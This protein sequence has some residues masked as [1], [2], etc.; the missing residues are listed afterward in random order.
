LVIDSQEE[1]DEIDFSDN[2]YYDLEELE[3]WYFS[4]GKLTEE[5]R[6]IDLIE[7]K[8][9]ILPE[10]FYKFRNLEKLSVSFS[11]S[12]RFFWKKWLEWFKKLTKL[13]EINLNYKDLQLYHN[14]EIITDKIEN[15]LKPY[16]DK[17]CV[18]KIN[19]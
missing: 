11:V 3:I 19:W 16:L 18:V 9:K 14:W 5:I 13:K 17:N 10:N 12:Q 6:E 1:F 2:K 7:I 4:L 15:N 8:S